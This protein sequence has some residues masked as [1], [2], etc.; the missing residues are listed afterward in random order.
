MEQNQIKDERTI[1]FEELMNILKNKTSDEISALKVKGYKDDAALQ[2]SMTTCDTFHVLSM[3]LSG[4]LVLGGIAGLGSL[5]WSLMSQSKHVFDTVAAATAARDFTIVAL[6][7]GG[8]AGF[9]ATGAAIWKSLPIFAV[10]N[11]LLDCIMVAPFERSIDKKKARNKEQH[12][13]NLQRINILQENIKSI[14]EIRENFK[15]MIHSSLKDKRFTQAEVELIYKY[16][17]PKNINA[18]I[19]LLYHDDLASLERMAPY[20]IDSLSLSLSRKIATVKEY[21]FE[22]QKTSSE[23]SKTSENK[24]NRRVERLHTYPYDDMIEKH[25]DFYEERRKASRR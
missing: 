25:D 17:T 6:A 15:Y 8:A 7:F 23:P 11:G 13:K 3:I 16:L 5:S 12:Q 9:V 1:N 2:N 18:V 4:A 10:V 21:S 22:L 20:E 19:Y 24:R 14:E